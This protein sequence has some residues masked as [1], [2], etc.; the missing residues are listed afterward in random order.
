[1]TTCKS[2]V[3]PAF[4]NKNTVPTYVIPLVIMRHWSDFVSKSY[5]QNY[6][7]LSD[8]DRII[9][10]FQEMFVGRENQLLMKTPGCLIARR[11][12]QIIA[13]NAVSYSATWRYVVCG[14]MEQSFGE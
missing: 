9:F 8:N 10:E 14:V 1:M 4:P 2:T 7:N 13:H 12:G 5:P 3:R 6:Y 11:D